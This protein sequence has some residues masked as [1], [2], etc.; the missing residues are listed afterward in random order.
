MYIMHFQYL[1]NHDDFISYILIMYAVPI[2]FLNVTFV[3][4]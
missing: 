4:S 3:V 1:C 2:L